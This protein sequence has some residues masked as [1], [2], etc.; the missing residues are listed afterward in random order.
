MD[1]QEKVGMTRQQLR[2][3]LNE[4][5]CD[6]GAPEEAARTLRDLLALCPL[7]EHREAF[8]RLIP[9]SGLQYLVLYTLGHFDLTEHGGSVGGC[10]LTDHGKAVLD[11]LNREAE[12]GFEALMESACM[13]GYS[14]ESAI[15][16]VTPKRVF[17]TPGPRSYG[18]LEFG[19]D[20]RYRFSI[21]EEPEEPK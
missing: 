2:A 19:V 20:G 17:G 15:V 18:V 10:W 9:D 6:C 4:W 1:Q 7:F 13:H 14:M 16:R 12:D 11:A 21:R 5:F 3:F 8:E